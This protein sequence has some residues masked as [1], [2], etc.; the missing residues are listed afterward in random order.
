MET[1]RSRWLADV[2]ALGAE[3]GR[4][5]L[6]AEGTDLLDRWL[7]DHRSYH[8]AVHLA[9]VLAA[10]DELHD[11][12]ELPSRDRHLAGLAAWFHDAVY[13]AAASAGANEE[14]SAVL[15]EDH[16][17]RL[18]LAE[19]DVGRVARLVRES[20]THEMTT[21]DPATK[22]FHDA[23]LWILAAPAQR[24]DAYCHQVRLEYRQVRAMDYAR[25]RT[26]VLTPFA[27]RERLYLTDHAHEQWTR[28]ARVNLTREIDRLAA[29]A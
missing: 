17:P 5:L 3:A 18:G 22:A 19:D 25:G 2:S 11:A 29:P 16:L 7:E 15:A 9:E 6:L 20:A 26:A 24:F 27:T 8:D 4:E 1:L 28:R 14:S 10:L 21:D 13:D 23:D 12:G